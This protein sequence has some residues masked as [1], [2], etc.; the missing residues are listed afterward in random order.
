[1]SVP[2]YKFVLPPCS[3]LRLLEIE[4]CCFRLA[5]SD[6]TSTSTEPSLEGCGARDEAVYAGPLLKNGTKKKVTY[7]CNISGSKLYIH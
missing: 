7:N 5:L 2:P 1:V 3:C 6:V 4:K